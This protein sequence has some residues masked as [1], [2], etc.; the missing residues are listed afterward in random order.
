MLE[1]YLD[2]EQLA[3]VLV[4]ALLTMDSSEPLP[5]QVQER[6]N[7]V[8]G[9]FLDRYPNHPTLRA[10]KVDEN[11]DE[12]FAH[13]RDTVGA[14]TAAIGEMSQRVSA[15]QVPYGM[16]SAIGGRPYGAALLHRAAG[17]LLVYPGDR[18]QATRDRVDAT[19]A[20]DRPAVVDASVLVTAS[21]TEGLW[22]LVRASLGALTMTDPA[23]QDVAA[24]ADSC[25]R[26][27]GT[28]FGWDIA[29]GRPTLDQIP[30][31]VLAELRRRAAFVEEHAHDLRHEAWP[32]QRTLDSPGD[33]ERRLDDDQRFWSWISGVDYA[34][35]NG[36]PLF[37]D[38][39]ALRMLARSEG[40]PT[41]G[42]AALVEVLEAQGTM[43]GATRR[44]MFDLWRS[45]FCV[46]LP[47]VDE[48]QEFARSVGY[49]PG[50]ATLTV[51]RPAF[52]QDTGALA[53]YEAICRGTVRTAPEH[54]AVWLYAAIRG[55]IANRPP[56]LAARMAADLLLRTE[57]ISA[58]SPAAFAKMV[59][60]ARDALEPT[61]AGLLL[62]EV[63]TP[64]LAKLAPLGATFGPQYVLGLS[65]EL[66]PE[67]RLIARAIAFGSPGHASNP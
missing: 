17:C 38:D 61:G 50:P 27:D 31:D 15:G 13:L 44:T 4:G 9:A 28:S 26:G 54:V 53:S 8:L 5:G 18:A 36:F 43:E 55:A 40:V 52:W 21:F 16:L 34:K 49:E 47:G 63:F 29:T 30:Q 12:L 20:L 48:L 62:A 60:A 67:D 2:D 7:A 19:R 58:P 57:E 39:V 37:C 65:S 3:A 10:I 22:P 42:S 51:A 46:D 32:T 59:A 66:P 1:R 33:P 25:R 64:L 45:E 41:F 35:T 14:S 11:F 24:A 56:E 6:W 23:F